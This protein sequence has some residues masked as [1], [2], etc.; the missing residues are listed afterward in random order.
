M[1]KAFH[2]RKYLLEFLSIFFGVSLAFYLNIWNEDRKSFFSE[3]KT[4]EEIRNGLMLDLEDFRSNRS[5]HQQGLEAIKYFRRLVLGSEVSGDSITLYYHMLLRD[6]ISVQN[7]SAYESLK[8]KGLETIKDDSLRL[9]IISLHD[10]HYEIIEKLEETYS[11]NQFNANYFEPIN[12]IFAPYFKF[13]EEGMLSGLEQPLTLS[14]TERN[15]LL[16]YLMR[17]EINRRYTMYFYDEME[18]RVGALIE[19]IES[20]LK[21]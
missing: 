13:N 19:E 14:K 8:S 12:N 3:T 15:H 7:K 16:I 4:L 20:Q 2:W 9:A 11:E 1:S 6:F 18:Q 21:H 10:F 17:M 5:G